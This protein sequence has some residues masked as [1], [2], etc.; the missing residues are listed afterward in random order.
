VTVTTLGGTDTEVR[1]KKTLQ[2]QTVD[3]PDFL[4][5]VYANDLL[6]CRKGLSVAED[7]RLVDLLA[8]PAFKCRAK[9]VSRL[10]TRA[11]KA[12]WCCPAFDILFTSPRQLEGDELL[13]FVR[14]RPCSRGQIEDLC[15]ITITAALARRKYGPT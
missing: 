5:D 14:Q 11:L 13:Y 8:F 1:L 7:L 15:G 10:K 4:R 2:L 9:R 3:Q 12:W 6:T